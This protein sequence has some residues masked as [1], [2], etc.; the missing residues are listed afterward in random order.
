MKLTIYRKMVTGFVVV[1]CI[2]IAAHAYTLFE[3]HALS[4]TAQ[5][6]LR[7][8]VQ[9]LDLTKRLRDLLDAEDGH[10]RKYLVTRD[11]TYYDLFQETTEEFRKLLVSLVLTEDQR[12]VLLHR[13]AE[14]HHSLSRSLPEPKNFKRGST[15]L[16]PVHVSEARKNHIE[17]IDRSLTGLVRMN[18]LSIDGSMGTFVEATQ[19]ATFVAGM[20][21]LLTIVA[22]SLASWLIA[23]T[24]TRPIARLVEATRQIARGVFDPIRVRSHDE[25]ALLAGAV[26]DMSAKLKEVNEAK[27]DLMH[28]IVHELRNP[29][30]IIF[31]ARNLLAEEEVGNVNGKQR[32]MLDLI[33][34]N[35]EKLMSFTNQF[36]DLAKADAGMMEYRR[37]PTDLVT[38]VSRAVQ[39]ATALASRKNI[40]IKLLSEPVPQ[41]L[42]DG[43][44]LAQVFSNLLS[45]AVK[46]TEGGGSISV[47]LFCIDRKIY[48]AVKDS[49]MGIADDELPMLFTKFYQATN[50]A[51]MRAKGTG[52][53]LALVKAF[54]EGH[55]G[56]ISVASTLGT[57]STF[58]V[59]IPLADVGQ[60]DS[61]AAEQAA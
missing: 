44:K 22:A 32:E 12:T 43:E 40:S 10:A 58:T 18:R 8:D 16:I 35:A 36:L 41:T 27:A 13:V 45:N 23:R 25:T 42:A 56:N 30:Q 17:V 34:S 2:M 15:A 46:Y 52:L 7:L 38:L 14:R 11:R 55:G 9:A 33:G 29:L 51:T 54:V 24:I 1:I 5:E 47:A 49:G 50:A 48:V 31:F 20:L 3:L 53:G 37:T 57:G 39:D 26:N 60:I 59:E 61:L 6:T 21:M 28:Q 4:N 19:R